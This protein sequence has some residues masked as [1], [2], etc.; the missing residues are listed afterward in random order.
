MVKQSNDVN[1]SELEVLV[2]NVSSALLC[3]IFKQLHNEDL[4]RP[5]HVHDDCLQSI[6]HTRP[7]AGWCSGQNV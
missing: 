6:N 2:V 1:S 3:S 7:A 5:I 4:E